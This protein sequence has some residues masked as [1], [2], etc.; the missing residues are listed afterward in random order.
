[1]ACGCCL[2]GAFGAFAPRLALGLIWVF[3]DWVS[4]AFDGDWIVPLA[5]LVLLPYTTLAYVALW[6]WGTSG[7]AGFD[8]FLVILAFFFD[9]GQY[10]SGYYGKGRSVTITEA[11]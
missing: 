4:W 8:W 7:V 6:N 2:L 5:G 1:M 11:R 3:T 10:T 9:I